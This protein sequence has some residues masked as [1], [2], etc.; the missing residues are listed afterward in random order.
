MS[1]HGGDL[2]LDSAELAEWIEKQGDRW[3]TVDGDPLLTGLITFPCPG[4]EL[5]AELRTLNRTLLVQDRRNNAGA[6]L[7][8]AKLDL[9]DAVV[10]MIGN[11][12][13]TTGEKHPRWLKDRFLCLRWKGSPATEWLLV[14]DNETTESSHEDLA[15]SGSKA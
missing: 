7:P 10:D 13:H 8:D 14:E 11:N 15:Q 5:A 4:D 6:A 9:I 12:M 2:E 1:N 3:W